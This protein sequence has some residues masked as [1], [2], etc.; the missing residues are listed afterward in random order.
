MNGEGNIKFGPVK[1]IEDL[2]ASKKIG[3]MESDF[4]DYGQHITEEVL[5]MGQNRVARSTVIIITTGMAEQTMQVRDIAPGSGVLVQIG[6]NIFGILTAGH[7][8]RRNQN[9]SDN[10]KLT[11]IPPSKNLQLTDDIMMIEL[12][13]RPCT[14]AGFHNETEDG[15]D[16]AIIPLESRETRILDDCGMVAYNLNKKRWS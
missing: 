4:R 9:T 6:N 11:V 1:W 2:I 13:S 8:L 7:V 5:K 12:S 16:I 3:V 14:V 10:V 15:P